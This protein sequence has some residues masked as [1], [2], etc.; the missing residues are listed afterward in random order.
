M[1]IDDEDNEQNDRKNHI[2]SRENLS[3]YLQIT[4]YGNKTSRLN[5]DLLKIDEKT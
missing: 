4:S 5:G 2:M 1:K 3:L